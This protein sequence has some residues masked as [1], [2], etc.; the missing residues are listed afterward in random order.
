MAIE[1]WHSNLQLAEF[2]IY[3]DQQAL[4]H[5]N[6]QCLHTIWQQKVFT[7]LLGLS[8]RVV[9][10]KG[11]ENS[12]TDALSRRVHLTKT[13]TAVSIVTPDWCTD[14]LAGYQSDPHAQKL[15]TKLSAQE[16]SVPHFTL[17]KGLLMYN[18]R[19][20]VGH[21]SSFQ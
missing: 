6:D 15:I 11:T 14:I 18:E 13:C 9:Y 12:A 1:Q 10:K 19:I 4:I 3:T 7:K 17:E 20:W 21:N 8:Y 5:L 16:D 2:T